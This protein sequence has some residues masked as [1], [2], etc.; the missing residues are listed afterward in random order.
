MR[1]P[2]FTSPLA[3]KAMVKSHYLHL[4]QCTA[5]RSVTDSSKLVQ[6]LR[7]FTEY[8][9]MSIVT[10]APKRSA[11]ITKSMLQAHFSSNPATSTP[12]GYPPA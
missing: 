4:T 11:S 12:L 1:I 3:T 10:K 5:L 2:P 8:S 9:D 6:P 7:F